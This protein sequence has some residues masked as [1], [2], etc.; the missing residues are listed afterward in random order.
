MK[1][2]FLAFLLCL[3]QALGASAF[4]ADGDIAV[5]MQAFKVV[6]TANGT[7]LQPTDKALP[8]DT[9]EYHV[10]YRNTGKTAARD[11]V[12]TLPVPAGGMA[13]VADSATPATVTASLDGQQFAPVPLQRT[14]ERDGRR[15]TETVPATEYRVLRWTLGELAA[16]RTAT[17]T[18][19]MRLAAATTN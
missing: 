11:V 10:A 18:S 9:I 12:A 19:R 4:A 13:Y 5:T 14:V 16:G 8:G 1:R 2:I 3:A 6:A 17:V 15:I 7:E